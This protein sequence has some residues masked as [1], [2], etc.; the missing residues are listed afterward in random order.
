MTT[1]EDK[2][3]IEKKP[4]LFPVFLTVFIDLIGLGIIIPVI[5]PLLLMP[6]SGILPV[7]MS[8]AEKSVILGFLIASFP[9][10]QF[11]GAPILGASISGGPLS[12]GVGCA[13]AAAACG[14]KQHVSLFFQK[15][16]FFFSEALGAGAA[17]ACGSKQQV[18][19]FFQ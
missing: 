7:G 5:A 19:F 8:M 11:F 2:K 16:S 18:S 17:A 15:V 9:L 4:S 12:G 14:S 6:Y 10:A 1:I 3:E 13:G